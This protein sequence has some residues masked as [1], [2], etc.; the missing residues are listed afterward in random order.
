MVHHGGAGT[1]AAGLLAGCP[2]F[3]VPFF[4]DQPFWG[5]SCHK[6]GVGPKPVSIDELDTE[7]LV[8]SLGYMLFPRV[9]QRA[10]EVSSAMQK[11]DGIEDAIA[12]FHRY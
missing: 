8:Y 2:T 10:R 9:V 5:E 1:T 11:E 12:A 3:V 4:G 6:A 7:K